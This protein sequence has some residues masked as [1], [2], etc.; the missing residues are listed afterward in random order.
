[1][2]PYQVVSVATATTLFGLNGTLIRGMSEAAVYCDNVYLMRIGT[3]QGTLLVG[4]TGA[5]VLGPSNTLISGVRLGGVIT[6]TVSGHVTPDVIQ[7]SSIVVA[8]FIVNVDFNT[9]W[10][11]TSLTVG[12]TNDVITI[13]DLGAPD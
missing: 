1:N 4:H 12:A 3:A 2:S 13:D 11:I 7:G 5:P 9:T 10:T 8:G 6:L